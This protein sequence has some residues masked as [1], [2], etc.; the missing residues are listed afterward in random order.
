M[1]PQQIHNNVGLQNELCTNNLQYISVAFK[2]L[3]KYI[4]AYVSISSEQA[5][6]ANIS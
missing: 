3:L 5:G 1:E 4:R 6:R 2:S